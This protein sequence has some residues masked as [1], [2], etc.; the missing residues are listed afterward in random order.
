MNF[1]ILFLQ[2]CTGNPYIFTEIRVWPWHWWENMSEILYILIRS[3]LK[4]GGNKRSWSSNT[5]I[6]TLWRSFAVIF[7]EMHFLA[8]FC[9]LQKIFLQWR[10]YQGWFQYRS[11]WTSQVQWEKKLGSCFHFFKSNKKWIFRIDIY[12]MCLPWT[13]T[14]W[15]SEFYSFKNILGTHSLSQRPRHDLGTDGKIYLKF[16]VFFFC[17][18]IRIVLKKK[19]GEA[20]DHDHPT[21]SYI[22]FGVLLLW[23]L[24]KC[25]FL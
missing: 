15:I 5:I 25:I 11:S 22:L 12:N 8:F 24:V 20:K 10:D 21:Q 19:E 1:G 4:K 16:Y 18:L 23:C 2:K 3:I 9:S 17:I 13:I 7:G 6:H 14:N